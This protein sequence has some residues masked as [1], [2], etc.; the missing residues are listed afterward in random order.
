MLE[1]V[2]RIRVLHIDDEPDLAETTASL[3]EYEDSRFNIETADSVSDGLTRIADGK[4][5]CIVSDY[6]LGDRTGIELLKEIRNEYPNLPFIL[7]TGKGSEDVAS[8]AF[9]AGATDYLQK[10]GGT[11]QYEL[12]ANRIQ[13]AVKQYQ[14]T[15]AQQWLVDLVENTDRV[16]FSFTADWDDVL[17]MS[18]SYEEVWGRPIATLQSNPTDFLQGIHPDDRETVRN[19]MDRVS[20]GTQLDIEFRVNPDEDYGRWVRAHMEPIG[21]GTDPGNR[22]GGFAADITEHRRRQDRHKR[23][24]ETL[25]KLATDD[26]V[27]SG[28]FQTAV[29]RITE[30]AAHVLEVPRVNVWLV[31]DAGDTEMLKCIDHY[32]TQTESHEQ[33]PVLVCKDYPA[34]LRALESHQAIDATDALEDPRTTELQDYLTDNDIGAL[35][36]GTLRSE[37]DVIGVVC[38]EHVGDTREW[39]DDEIDFASDIADIV[40]RAL[41]NRER[42]EREEELAQYRSYID[43]VFDTIDDVFFV[44]AEDGSLIRWND[45]FS[46]VTGYTDTE[47]ESMDPVD[48][49]T[50]ADRDETVAA[51][52]RVIDEGHAQ[53]EASLETKDGTTI[54]YEFV[55]NRVSHPDGMTRLVGIGRDISARLEREQKLERIREQMAFALDF[56]DSILWAID[57]ETEKS[58]EYGPTERVF[59]VEPDGIDDFIANVVHPDD[60]EKVSKVFEEVREHETEE[61]NV[62]FRT[63]PSPDETRWV[64]SIGYVRNVETQEPD[65]LVGLATDVTERRKRER[66]LQRQNA[67]LEEFTSVVSHDLRNPLSVAE[68][69][70]RLAQ[71][72]CDS[73][74]LED[75]E[76]ALARIDTLVSDLLT[77]AREGEEAVEQDVFNLG[78]VARSCWK[79]VETADATLEI[80][81]DHEV[82]ADRN[83]LRQLFEN[84]YRNAVEHGGEAVTITV[85]HLDGGFYIEDDGPG[86]PEGDKEE[87]FKAGH[88]TNTDGTGFGL[89]I[90][91]QIV[92][93]HDW[94][95]RAT[96]GSA[97][98]A[99]FEITGVEFSDK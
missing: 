27:T 50:E 26:A 11:S 88:S 78:E 7:F 73:E 41:R 17:F 99:R 85:G 65:R 43:R 4:F 67:R 81:L 42:T 54:P 12:L 38:H 55:T 86:I 95:I 62:E 82:C 92:E 3:L 46:K 77:L 36:D 45:S 70:L 33:G 13:N 23:Q 52:A 90:I 61:F 2:E 29:Q 10:K 18:S 97:G 74:H 94:N 22:I 14:S 98:G 66:E 47:I 20:E 31:D 25:L 39:T 28:D 60:R 96:T 89:S 57:L 37:G 40:H 58:T 93:A 1:M 48:F 8:Q 76:T 51:I 68:G 44:L 75:V 49:M 80:E 59:G 32:D 56:T 69:R 24:R 19:A 83:R 16:V 87:V 71:A 84:C 9:S 5:D 53:L 15:R 35:L 6:D 34:Y 91:Q 79:T 30:A 72:D 63:V 64:L 21:T